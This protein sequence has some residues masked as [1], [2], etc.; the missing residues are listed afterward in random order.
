VIVGARDD[1]TAQLVINL[2]TSLEA[3]GLHAGTMI[4]EAAALIGGG[5]GGR[6]TM[7][8]AGGKDADR[9][10]DAVALAERTILEA[11]G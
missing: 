2:D 5:G 9:L 11:L 4:R 3:R 10:P 7:A 6:P 8:R 1:G